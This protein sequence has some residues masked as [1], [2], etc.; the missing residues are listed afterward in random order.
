MKND[1]YLT[2][3]TPS[4]SLYKEKGSKFLGF[5]FPVKSEN[6]VKSRLEELRNKHHDARHH[7]YAYLLGPSGDHYRMND[8]GEP[9]STAGK[10]ILGQIRSHKL[11]NVLIVVV[12]YFGGTLLGTSGLIRAYKT[13]A[14]Q[15]IQN[16]RII[17]KTLQSFYELEFDYELM[18]EV[19]KL[20]HELDVQPYEREFQEKCRFRL[21]IRKNRE[22]KAREY[23]LKIPRLEWKP[24]DKK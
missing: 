4:E 3:A 6:D 22:E 11:T 9:S 16:G 23:F 1:E 24:L 5:A 17:K 21:G 8:D 20:L 7:C 19:M 12:R 18:N 13:A 2:L 10:P 14:D 15:A